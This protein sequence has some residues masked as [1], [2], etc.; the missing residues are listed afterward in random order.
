LATSSSIVKDIEHVQATGLASVAYHY[1]DFK[2]TGKQDRRSFLSSILNQLCTWSHRGYDVLSSLYEKHANGL[3]QPSDGDLI[4]CLK[5]VL[6]LP[7]QGRVYIIMDALDECPNKPG[8]PSPREKVLHLVNELVDLRH[9]DVRICIT[10]RPEADIRMDLDH[11]ASHTVSLH[12]EGGQS[13]DIINFVK[14]F[15]ESDAKMRRWR[16]DERQM[17]INSLS[18]N[19]DGM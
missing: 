11:L 13:N 5:N 17:V 9:P 14:S 7:G 8:I 4:Q 12:N 1:F 19:A 6:S 10:S 2:D 16:A 18:R 15:V 3:R